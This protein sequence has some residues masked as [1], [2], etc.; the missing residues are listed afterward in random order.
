V[1]VDVQSRVNALLEGAVDMIH[2][3]NGEF[4]GDLRDEE[5]IEIAE[6]DAFGETGYLLINNSD[7]V[8]S[9]IRV[10]RALAL[11]TDNEAI[12]RDR[13]GGV[14]PPANGPFSPTQIGHL[15]DTGYP[16]FDLEEAIAL[17]EE[18]E[19]EN[20]PLS[21]TFDTTNDP[22]N[23]E[24]NE[25]IAA[26]WQAA[27]IDVAIN[28]VEQGQFIINALTGDFQVFGWRNHGGVNPDSQRV[29]WHSETST[30]GLALNFGRIRDPE[31]DAL[32]DTVRSSTDEADRQA[33]AEDINRLFGEQV[34]NIWNTWTVWGL[35]H[36]PTV[37]CI[38]DFTFPDGGSTIPG[39]GIAGTHQIV[40]MWVEQ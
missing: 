37:H 19:A 1:F 3:S 40:Q 28:T 8:M 22:Y 34:Y 11:A 39:A 6:T 4:I 7:P 23:R 26:S 13:E 17:V 5:G 29:W 10:R 15:E 31:L 38:D 21:I 14:E 20:G 9:D 25:F 2:L 24:T 36:L 32:L 16:E 35:P 33:A 18:Y 30:Q 12:S 27:G